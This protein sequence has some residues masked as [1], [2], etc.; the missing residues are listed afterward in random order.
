MEKLRK[1]ARWEKKFLLNINFNLLL[2]FLFIEKLNTKRK[3]A[4]LYYVQYTLTKQQ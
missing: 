4:N 2:Q 1:C 3:K